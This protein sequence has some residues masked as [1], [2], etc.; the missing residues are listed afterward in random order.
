MDIWLALAITG[1]IVL[2]IYCT[3]KQQKNK[4]KVE[5]KIYEQRLFDI[6]GKIVKLS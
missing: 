3:K 6:A 2:G 5:V 4:T 1:S